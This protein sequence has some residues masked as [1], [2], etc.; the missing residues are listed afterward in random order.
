[1]VSKSAVEVRFSERERESSF[2]KQDIV[3][4][5]S[6]GKGAVNIVVDESATEVG[7][8]VG[9]SERERESDRWKRFSVIGDS[10]SR[11]SSDEVGCSRI[12]GMEA[13]TKEDSVI[14]F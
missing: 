5:K 10:K 9:V 1:M 12:S 11:I 4:R 8:I 6:V 13:S 7:I 14:I 2:K 3:V